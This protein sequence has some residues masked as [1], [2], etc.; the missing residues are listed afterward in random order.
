MRI[1]SSEVRHLQGSLAAA[2]ARAE[3]GSIRAVHGFTTGTAADARAIAPERTGRLIEGIEHRAAGLLGEVVSTAPYSE[4]VEEGTSDTAPQPFM[5]PA[6]DL[7]LPRLERRI[8][9]AGEDVL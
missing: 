3:A 4:Y 6:R 8:G 7:N 1:D 9:D 2:P 5:E